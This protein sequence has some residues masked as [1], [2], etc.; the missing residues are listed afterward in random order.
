MFWRVARACFIHE[1]GSRL[2]GMHIIRPLIVNSSDI[3][4]GAAIASSAL[5]R[6]FLNRGTE[7][8]MAV[9]TASSMADEETIHQIPAGSRVA[10]RVLGAVLPRIGLNHHH[11]LSAFALRKMQCFRDADVVNY[12]LLHGGYFNTLALPRLCKAKPGVLTLHD[13]WAFTGHCS[14]SL[15]CNRWQA[16]CGAC[17]YPEMEP[18]IRHDGTRIE[19]NLK[20]R[21]YKTSRLHVIAISR[22]MQN[23][24]EKSILSHLPVHHIPN[25]I[26]VDVFRPQNAQESRR[27][28]GLPSDRRLI[29]FAATWMEEH[30]KGADLLMKSLQ[31]L[32]ED[33]RN[34]STLVIMGRGN[35]SLCAASA[36][37]VFQLGFIHDDRLKALA[38]SAADVFAF[39]TRADNLPLVLQESMACGTPMVSFAVGGVPDLVRDGET[40][41]V[42]SCENVEGF[43]NHLVAVLRNAQLRAMLSHRC[44]EIAIREYSI[45]LQA[46]RYLELF[47]TL[48]LDC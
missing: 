48:I 29:L 44:R 16:A 12:H 41:F 42:A 33:L 35:A 45:E 32:P 8:H 2:T 4:G 17:P 31:A 37:P 15:D 19:L 27:L 6:A 38:Y 28:L 3:G 21:S 1:L 47:E 39:P 14:Y 20:R 24:V 18:A 30:R 25:G 5:H 11:S 36:I 10:R 40:G 26:D 23:A 13:M 9:G 43:T 7:S 46:D 22:W 34:T